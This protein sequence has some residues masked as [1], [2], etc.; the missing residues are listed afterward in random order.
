M[1]FQEKECPY[2]AYG[3]LIIVIIIR[4]DDDDCT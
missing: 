4:T 1:W 2:F 3:P